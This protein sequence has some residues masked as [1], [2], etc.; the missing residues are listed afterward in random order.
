LFDDLRPANQ[1]EEVPGISLSLEL[2]D[3]L[4]DLKVEA[5]AGDAG[6]GY[7][8]LLHAVYHHLEA[9]RVVNLPR[10]QTDNNGQNWVLRSYD[11]RG[12]PIYPYGY[13]LV[14]N[15]Y[16]DRRQRSKWACQPSYLKNTKPRVQLPEVTYPHPDCSN[17]QPDYTHGRIVNIGVRF[18]DGSIHLVRDVPVDSLSWKRRYHRARNA[19]ESRDATFEAWG[20]K[21]LPVYGSPRVTALIFLVDILNNLTTITHLIRQATLTHQDP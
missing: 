14:A 20:F 19:V 6:Y 18:H 17:Q 15:R 4:P 5:V 13:S 12:R 10:H 21:R 1:R 2:H 8:V 16:D 3:H 9:R 7:F 11:D